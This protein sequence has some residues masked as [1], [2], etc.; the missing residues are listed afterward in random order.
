METYGKE[1]ALDAIE[2][3]DGKVAERVL[4]RLRVE[5]PDPELVTLYLT[6]IAKTYGVPWPKRA[7][8]V[9][10]ENNDNDDQPGGGEGVK[11]PEP[12]LLA[13]ELVE[14]KSPKEFDPS[15][16]VARPI[17][18]TDS[19]IRQ[20]QFPPKEEGKPS[21]NG[22]S[23][24]ARQTLSTNVQAAASTRDSGRSKNVVGGNIPDVD[25]LSKRFA[26]LKR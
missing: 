7:A 20:L 1:F 18:R 26:A 23:D 15:V 22:T 8:P 9:P 24:I 25:E 19:T 16:R 13:E 12:P 14:A 21:S 2:N 6:E 11:I 4:K 17:P 5:P 3:R 10:D